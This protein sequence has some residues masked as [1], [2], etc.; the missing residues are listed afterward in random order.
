MGLSLCSAKCEN[1]TGTITKTIIC[2][3]R[4]RFEPSVHFEVYVAQADG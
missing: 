2:Y 3:I 1:A 4:I